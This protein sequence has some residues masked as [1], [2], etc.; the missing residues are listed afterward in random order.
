[1]RSCSCGVYWRAAETASA[2]PAAAARRNI[3]RTTGE[4]FI[5]ASFTSLPGQQLGSRTAGAH[6]NV[7]KLTCEDKGRG[8]ESRERRKPPCRERERTGEFQR[9]REQKQR[10][11][12]R[13]FGSGFEFFP[14]VEAGGGGPP[15]GDTLLLAP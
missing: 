5:G 11:R 6:N 14:M 13:G 15:A 3:G 9:P 1:M 4:R 8:K 7:G 12:L 10:T 2:R